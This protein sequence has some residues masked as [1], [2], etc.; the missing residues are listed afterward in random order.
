MKR[1]V[2]IE[3]GYV[4]DT[5]VFTENPGIITEDSNDWENYF[6]DVKYPCLYIGIFVIRV[7]MPFE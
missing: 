5:Q 6:S 1:I 3:E 4:R 7:N 2:I